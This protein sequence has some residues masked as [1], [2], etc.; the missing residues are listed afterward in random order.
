MY[1]DWLLIKGYLA[2]GFSIG[3]LMRINSFFPDIKPSSVQ[4]DPSLIYLL[5]NPTA[6]PVDSQPVSLQGK[7]LG[8]RGISNW[9]GQDLIMQSPTGLVKLHQ[10]SWLG[11]VGNFWCQS[12]SPRDLI[13]QHLIATGWFR[14]GATPWIDIDTLRTKTG[15]IS[16]SSH[17]FWSTLLASAAAIWGAYIILWGKV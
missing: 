3:T 9:L 7:L 5:A 17:P 16:R 13:G 11:P 1:G 10:V 8:R 14:R 15:K 12:P 2:I 4:P 6:L